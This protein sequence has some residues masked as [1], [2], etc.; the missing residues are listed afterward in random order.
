[1]TRFVKYFIHSDNLNSDAQRIILGH[2]GNDKANVSQTFGDWQE[3]IVLVLSSDK[4]KDVLNSLTNGTF[5]KVEDHDDA[6]SMSNTFPIAI[7]DPKYVFME[8][9]KEKPLDNVTT[10]RFAHLKSKVKLKNQK[11]YSLINIGLK[12]PIQLDVKNLSENVDAHKCQD[13]FDIWKSKFV[14]LTYPNFVK[15]ENVKPSTVNQP[16]MNQPNV[17]P[18]NVNPS[19]VNPPNVNP[20]VVNSSNASQ[21]SSHFSAANQPDVKPPNQHLQSP[22]MKTSIP[23]SISLPFVPSAPP[24]ALVESQTQDMV[25]LLDQDNVNLAF[26]PNQFMAALQTINSR[27][28]QLD[29]NS[30]NVML[31]RNSNDNP[32]N[33]SKLNI[34]KSLMNFPKVDLEIDGSLNDGLDSLVNVSRL[35]PEKDMPTLILTF[36]TTN[37]MTDVIPDLSNAQLRN[38]KMFR[39]FMLERYGSPD[40]VATFNLIQ[41][42]HMEDPSTLIGRIKRAW[43]RVKNQDVDTPIPNSELNIIRD[44][45]IKSIRNDELR[46]KLRMWSTPYDKLLTVTRDFKNAEK[47]EENNAQSTPGTAMMAY[48]SCKHCGLAHA[49]HTCRSNPKQKANYNKKLRNNKPVSR[50]QVRIIPDRY[51]N[52]NKYQ[53][54]QRRPVV[55]T[56]YHNSN[57]QKSNKIVT[58]QKY[59]KPDSNFNR[60][61]PNH[62]GQRQ[63]NYGQKQNNYGQKSN[64]YDQRTNGGK[65][66]WRPNLK[67]NFRKTPFQRNSYL[68]V[69]DDDSDYFEYPFNAVESMAY[70]EY[71]Q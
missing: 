14:N 25:P 8:T 11:S 19:N 55:N 3:Q 48:E 58:F 49:S 34:T 2:F 62:Y 54:V 53:P 12:H 63:N 29:L 43:N 52:D 38:A 61:K 17:N 66:P 59:Q 65:R 37:S 35:V 6:Y 20:P 24:Q 57:Q 50:S 26:D 45:F 32:I 40:P 31:T 33:T 23:R 64:Q 36:L 67:K 60:Q 70:D 22:M 46:K 27:I 41:E 4:S 16:N 69:G 42:R 47:L 1:M 18:S 39:N 7:V 68:A 30:N 15:D 44:R 21:T 56:S 10:A 9:R 51:G 5:T 71:H 13:I 28:D